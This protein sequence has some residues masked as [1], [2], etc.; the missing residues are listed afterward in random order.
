MAECFSKALITEPL[1]I[2]I[3]QTIANEYVTRKMYDEAYRH[4]SI[5]AKIAPNAARAYLGMG[6][7][8]LAKGDLKEA[9]K[10]FSRAL[11]LLPRNA[12]D[13]KDVLK[14]L[15]KAGG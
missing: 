2:N 3:R 11:S 4:F 5:M 7:A 10:Q 12:P 14:L 8:M 6:K 1:N 9:R 13:R 15:E